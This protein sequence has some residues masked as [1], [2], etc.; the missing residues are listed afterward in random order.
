[1]RN[2]I[3]L[4]FLILTFLNC[5]AQ[6]PIISIEDWDG[7]EQQDAYFKDTNN[8]LNEYVGTWLYTN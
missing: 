1:M 4:L 6:S 8:V 7:S 2:L 5:K 3:T